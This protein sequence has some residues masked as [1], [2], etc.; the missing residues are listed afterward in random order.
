M[1]LSPGTLI[2]PFKPVAFRDIRDWILGGASGHFAEFD[3]RVKLGCHPL[4]APGFDIRQNPWHGSLNSPS[5]PISKGSTVVKAELGTK[6]TCPSC[7]SRF[8]DLLK[9][10]IVC[11]KCGV[12]FIAA[13]ILPSKGDYP[14]AAPAPVAKVR[15]KVEV[16][17]SENA[18]VELIS[19]EDVEED[20]KDDDET[21]G[22]EDVDLGEDAEPA[23]A[24]EDDT[25]LVVEEEEGDNVSGLLDS[26]PSGGKEGEEEV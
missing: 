25:F 9:N 5:Y 23:D 14:G 18:D 7:A 10:P 2:R 26:G 1:D 21:A 3:T 4:A 24:E 17:E 16:E 19:L 6:R 11:P 12:S 13:P 22:I 15:E 8:Y 20:G